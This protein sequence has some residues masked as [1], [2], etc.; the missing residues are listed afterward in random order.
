MGS[1]RAVIVSI[2]VHTVVVA[3][4]AAVHEDAPAAKPKVGGSAMTIVDVAPIEVELLPAA[5]GGDSAAAAAGDDGDAPATAH[6]AHGHGHGIAATEG[7]GTGSGEAPPAPPGDGGGDE[8]KP[9]NLS[10]SG[11]VIA[12]I[13]NK[14]APPPIPHN[15]TSEGG[16]NLTVDADGSAHVDPHG[17]AE[18]HVILPTTRKEAGEMVDEWAKD[19]DA[20][21]AKE[22]TIA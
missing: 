1:V 3:V 22:G 10:I 4:L 2:V 19:P 11:D 20:Y 16:T 15:P 13:L 9:L 8:H 7:T 12:A 5:S 18:T 14:P 6:R 21:T 17:G